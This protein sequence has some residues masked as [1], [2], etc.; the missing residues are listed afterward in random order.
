MCVNLVFDDLWMDLVVSFVR[1][2]LEPCVAGANVP[3]TFWNVISDMGH[4]CW[5]RIM[6]GVSLYIYVGSLRGSFMCLFVFT[7]VWRIALGWRLFINIFLIVIVL[8]Q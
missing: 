8:I 5:D 6:V 4:V 7:I 3:L 1:I 2:S